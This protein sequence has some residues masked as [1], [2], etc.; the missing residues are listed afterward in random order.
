[1][2]TI[3]DNRVILNVGGIR[4]ETYKATLKKIPATRLSR[5]T[6]ALANYDPILNEY[7]FDRH[8]GVFA[9]IL[10]Y[11]RTGKL[12]YPTDVCG[13]LFEEELEF[14]GLDS[15]QVE[16][17]CWM[18][19]TQH[20]DTQDVLAILDRLDLDTDKPTEEDIMK[21]FGWEEEYRAGELNC[22]QRIQPK[23]WA[24]FDEPYSS[25]AAKVRRVIAVVSVFFIV[26][27]I[28]SFCLK[29]HP[30]MRVPVLKNTTSNTSDGGLSWR[31]EKKKTEPHQAF[32]YIE[33]A[34]NAWFTFEI[35]IRL[36]VAPNKLD[37]LKAPVNIIDIIATLSFYLDFMLTKLKQENDI[38]EFFSIIRIMR[39][40]K[41]TR[42]SAGLKILIHTFKASAKELV[43]LVFFLV[44][45]I[46]IFAA[47]IFYAERIQYNP[48]NDFTSIPVGLWWA[49]V[50]MT[51]VGYGDMAPKTYVGM[52][53]GALCALLGVLTIA[54][55]VPVIVSNF[56][57]FYSHT[58]ARSKLPKK[59]RRVLPVEL[60]RPKGPK[61]MG[62]GGG[63]PPINRHR[64]AIKHP[65]VGQPDH[66]INRMAYPYGYFLGRAG[67]ESIPMLMINHTDKEDSTVPRSRPQS[68]V[69]DKSPPRLVEISSNPGTPLKV[70]EIKPSDAAGITSLIMAPNAN[71]NSTPVG[72]SN[73]VTATTASLG[74][75]TNSVTSNVTTSTSINQD[76]KDLVNNSHVADGATT[77]S[78]KL[79]NSSAVNNSAEARH[80]SPST[81]PPKSNNLVAVNT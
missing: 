14:W 34:S 54:L 52:F 44:L 22:W 11:Y 58:Q 57:L 80:Y 70:T 81:S 21:K 3:D 19:Y 74:V 28:L 50:T 38:L 24:L 73:S 41:L 69:V 30:E 53:V 1:M 39:L 62:P 33:C 67:E 48:D 46:V 64:N 13:P 27:S 36:I 59:R 40:C 60:P 77:D 47:L 79:S 8:P 35:I 20:R 49:I 7:F 4:H 12:H 9:Q 43:L 17:C 75:T 32:F 23:I 16:P 51:T 37:F 25:N 65:P 72:S 10:N 26:V 76:K 2:T 6:E 56:A 45:G 55:P 78:T 18:T 15:N 61:G 5:L 68:N 42:H 31:L 63:P 29:T 71:L 66:K